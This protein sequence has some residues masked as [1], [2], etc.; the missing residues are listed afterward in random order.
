MR[1]GSAGVIK[2]TSASMHSTAGLFLT[3][4]SEPILKNSENRRQA[5]PAA[6]DGIDDAKGQGATCSAAEFLRIMLVS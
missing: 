2:T 1:L 4:C 3:A 6:G 5:D